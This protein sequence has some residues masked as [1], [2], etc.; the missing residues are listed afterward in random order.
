MYLSLR[1]RKRERE[2]VC[3]CVCVF[4]CIHEREKYGKKLIQER[5]N[6]YTSLNVWMLLFF[7][8]FVKTERDLL[9]PFLFC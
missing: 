3:V 2:S 1:E 6:D 7:V 5:Q 4:V 8:V 9:H